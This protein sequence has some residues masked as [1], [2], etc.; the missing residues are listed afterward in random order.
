VQTRRVFAAGFLTLAFLLGQP[1]QCAAQIDDLLTSVWGS[2]C[3]DVYA[4]GQQG[5]VYHFDGQSWQSLTP[6]TD[7]YLWAVWGFGTNDVYAA[8]NGGVL[9]YF[10]GSG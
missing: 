7:E 9:F 5:A 3:N 8:G 10:D 6:F 2:S 1:S 4:V